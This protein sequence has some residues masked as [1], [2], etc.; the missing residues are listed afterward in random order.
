[1][2][3]MSVGFRLSTVRRCEGV[4]MRIPSV[5]LLT[6]LLLLFAPITANALDQGAKCQAGKLKIAAKYGSCRL[7]Q[8]ARSITRGTEPDHFKCRTQFRTHWASTESKWGG[9]CPTE[10]DW[11]DI[12]TMVSKHADQVTGAITGPTVTTTTTTLEPGSCS[13]ISISDLACGLGSDCGQSI[14]GGFSC[15]GFAA[16]LFTAVRDATGQTIDGAAC[17]DCLRNR[18]T[19]EERLVLFE[20]CNDCATCTQGV[21]LLGCTAECCNGK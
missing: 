8:E 14:D 3:R 11:F 20:S 10:D 19:D 5:L 9:L 2:E 15:L 21:D 16:G 12:D 13:T 4:V 6:G 18:H 7:R 17:F 1:M